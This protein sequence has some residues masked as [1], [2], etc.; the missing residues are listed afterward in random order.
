MVWAVAKVARTFAVLW[1][2]R[3]TLKTLKKVSRTECETLN[4]Y[5]LRSSACAD[6][7]IFWIVFGFIVCWEQ[8]LELFVRWIPGKE[9]G[10]VGVG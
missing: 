10:G 4:D 9:G 7:L 6:A 8:Y 2:V 5:R 3:H 1:S